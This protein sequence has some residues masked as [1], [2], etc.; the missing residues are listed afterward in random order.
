LYGLYTRTGG[1]RPLSAVIGERDVEGWWL[2][3]D[4][5][6]YDTVAARY[7]DAYG[8][9]RLHVLPYELS[10]TDPTRSRT[11]R[12]STHRSTGW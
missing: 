9:E 5:L 2:R 8:T 6:E 4:Y 12:R 7:A 10:R 11:S 3:P 1:H